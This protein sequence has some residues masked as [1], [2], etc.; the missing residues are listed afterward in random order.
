MKIVTLKTEQFD[1]FATK[2][3]Y[4]SFYQTS[5]YAR[6]MLKFGYSIHFLGFVDEKSSLIGATFI[7]YKQVFMS[8]KIAYA[9]RGILFNFEN[10]DKVKDMVDK[11]KQVLGK[12]GFML[13][14]IDPYIPISI[15]SNDGDIIN[16]NNQESIILENLKANGFQ[17]KGKNFYFENEKPRWEALVLLNKAPNELLEQFSDK[18]KSKIKKAQESGL[19]IYK[20]PE[21]NIKKLY[22]FIKKEDRKPYSY[23]EELSKNFGSDF[24]VYYAKIK[25]ETFVINSRKSYEEELVN[26]EQLA[27]QIQSLDINDKERMNILNKKMASDKLITAYKKHILMATELLKKYPE[28]ITVSGIITI[29]YDNASYILAEGYDNEYTALNAD[30][31]LKWHL[32]CKGYERRYKYINL[33]G[34]SGDF[35]ANNKYKIL[36]ESKLGFNTVVSEY[37]G[38]FDIILNNFAYNLYKNFGAKKN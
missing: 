33:G 4:R 11:L 10:A 7:A 25:P 29:N 17:Y 21:K 34:V 19:E 32:I 26:N 22:D 15:R 23:F 38:E 5:S 2:H 13:L 6:S 31:L 24:E 3:R 28:G 37:I 16:I 12:Q 18:T 36:N 9:P 20:D 27:E 35:S 8:N 30:Y 1:R 14:R